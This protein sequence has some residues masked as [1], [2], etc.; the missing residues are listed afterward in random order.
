MK[1]LKDFRLILSLS[2][3]G[4][5]IGFD[6]RRGF[7][8]GSQSRGF[9]FSGANILGARVGS[10]RGIP[11]VVTLVST[12]AF[13]PAAEAKPFFDTSR[14][15]R[16][17]KFRE[18]DGVDVHSVGVVSIAR[19]VDGRGE[20]SSFQCENTH[21][22][23][24]EHL[25]LF[26]PSGDGDRDRGHGED[27]GCELL[28]KPQG[29]LINEG[30]V[31]GDACF[32]GEVLEVSDVLLEAVVSHAVRAFEGFLGELGELEVCGCLGVVGEEGG[33]KV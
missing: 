16:R 21:L 18:G 25:G 8:G 32:R 15:F 6:G 13:L 19:G 9:G 5:D 20:S 10:G 3:Q 26:D 31:V 22:L 11:G 14:P 23:C 1:Y 29:E 7:G 2:L 30:Y 4:V 12:V 28:V 24:V 17:G 27:H 33:F